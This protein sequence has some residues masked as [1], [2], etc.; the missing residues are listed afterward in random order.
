MLEHLK[1]NNFGLGIFGVPE[2]IDGGAAKSRALRAP[3]SG[4]GPRGHHNR[5]PKKQF[6]ISN[7]FQLFHFIFNHSFN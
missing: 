1:T 4:G 3:A 5:L 7:R 2:G 6:H